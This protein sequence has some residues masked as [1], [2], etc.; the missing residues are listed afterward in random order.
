M[1]ARFGHYLNLIRFN[2]PIGTLLLFYPLLITFIWLD[3]FLQE[4]KALIVVFFL[5]AFLMRSAGCVINDL[6]DIKFDKK[7]ERTKT[8]PLA[9]GD[10]TKLEAYIILSILLFSGLCLLVYLGEVVLK[11]GIFFLIPIIIYPLTKRFFKLP[12]LFLGLTFNLGVFLV[13]VILEG[14]ISYE[15]FI[16][17]FSFV[18]W[19]IGYDTIYAHQD[20]EDDKKIGVKSTA[21]TFGKYSRAIILSCYGAFFL[22]QFAFGLIL[23]H[24]VIYFLFIQAFAIL[25]ISILSR[26]DLEDKTDCQ[27]FFKAN[28][29]IAIILIAII[30]LNQLFLQL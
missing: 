9:A 14:S 28:N 20:L 23:G 4:S 22:S 8:R 21:I 6:C 17:Y 18:C 29:K 7:V 24:N 3:P 15:V 25:I 30:W 10:I 1:L 27:I 12:Q 11:V 5:G 2:K 26:C 13:W 19:T 16:L